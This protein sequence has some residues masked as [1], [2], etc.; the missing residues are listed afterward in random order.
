MSGVALPILAMGSVWY[1]TCVLKKFHSP[2]MRMANIAAPNI[3]VATTLRVR[4][5][6]VFAGSWSLQVHSSTSVSS[7]S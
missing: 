2:I 1:E 7:A 3:G 5:L 4:R 6:P